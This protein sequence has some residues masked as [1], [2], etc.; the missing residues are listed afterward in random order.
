[1]PGKGT[2]EVGC[3]RSI[4]PI[5]ENGS[6]ACLGIDFRCAENSGPVRSGILEPNLMGYSEPMVT[7]FRAHGLRIIL[8]TDQQDLFLAKWREIHS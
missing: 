6:G 8:F 5:R 3:W 7:L 2:P 1:M 4:V